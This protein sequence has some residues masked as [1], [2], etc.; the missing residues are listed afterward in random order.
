MHPHQI[1]LILSIFGTI[2][3]GGPNLESYKSSNNDPLCKSFYNNTINLKTNI[4]NCNYQYDCIRDFLHN[5]ID[6]TTDDLLYNLKKINA[7]VSNLIFSMLK[8]NSWHHDTSTY[9]DDCSYQYDCIKEHME[10][11]GTKRIIDTKEQIKNQFTN[12]TYKID[13]CKPHIIIN[14]N[15]D[16]LN[17]LKKLNHS[18]SNLGYKSDLGF[19]SLHNFSI[20]LKKNININLMTD[21]GL[22]S[23][24]RS[25]YYS[26]IHSL[27]ESIR[28]NVY[29]NTHAIC[30]WE[31]QENN[32]F[33]F[34]FF[35]IIIL[36]IN[37]FICSLF[38]MM[39][40]IQPFNCYSLI[41]FTI[42]L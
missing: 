24:V 29:F 38:C 3:M 11:Y 39:I 16:I 23:L 7:S 41:F 14:N 22:H 6:I 8:L 36:H 42:F 28:Y 31:I 12:T 26:A 30:K 34:F 32:T 5:N 20:Y 40:G 27:H 21:L 15:T 17:S 13:L 1:K 18:I 2:Y 37:W 35:K 19:V 9:I 33:L 4:D 10:L 25:E